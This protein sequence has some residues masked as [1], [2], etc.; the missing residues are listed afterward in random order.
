METCRAGI[1][2]KQCRNTNCQRN[3]NRKP[4]SQISCTIV[5]TRSG[6]RGCGA[7]AILRAGCLNRPIAMPVVDV[8]LATHRLRGTWH[9]RCH[10]GSLLAFI[11][12]V[13]RSRGGHRVG[14]VW[15]VTVPM[16]AVRFTTNRLGRAWC[17]GYGRGIRSRAVT[18]PAQK[19][20][21]LAIYAPTLPRRKWVMGRPYQWSPCGS[22]PTEALGDGLGP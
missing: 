15:A 17:G 1:H 13:A 11:K 5:F 2:L 14:R 22:H 12:R 3:Y 8:R 19:G 21:L 18:V 16:I 6:R 7:R 9:R 4:N 10:G 20:I